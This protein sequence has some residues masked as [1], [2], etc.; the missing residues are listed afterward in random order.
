MAS[1]SCGWTKQTV[2]GFGGWSEVRRHLG[3]VQEA[4]TVSAP[5]GAGSTPLS[6]PAGRTRAPMWR[7]D[8]RAI[9]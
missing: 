4:L 8:R 2:S 7:R 3:R 6:V 9:S 1:C 5:S